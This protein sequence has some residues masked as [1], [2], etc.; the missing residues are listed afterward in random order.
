VPFDSEDVASVL[1]RRRVGVAEAHRE[2][3]QM[4]CEY[5]SSPKYLAELQPYLFPTAT[6]TEASTGSASNVSE[7]SPT[8]IYDP[9]TLRSGRLMQIGYY[10]G[11]TSGYEQEMEVY[12]V[13]L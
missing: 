9:L 1:R 11:E 4:T 2:G 8:S 13:K 3:L 6:L 10:E 7:R 12:G 5:P